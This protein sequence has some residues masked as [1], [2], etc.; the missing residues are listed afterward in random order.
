MSVPSAKSTVMS[1]RAYLAT[2]RSMVWRGRP[3]SSTSIGAVMRVSTSPGVMPG[4]L[5]MILTWVVDTSGKASIGVLRKLYQPPPTSSSTVSMI[6]RRWVSENWISRAS[7]I[8]RPRSRL[9]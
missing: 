5:T 2:E 9:P 8:Q 7:I 6:R 1:V 3:S 4:A